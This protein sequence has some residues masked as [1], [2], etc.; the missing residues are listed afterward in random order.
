MKGLYKAKFSYCSK[1]K[2]H[3]D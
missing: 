3:F 2:W 1:F